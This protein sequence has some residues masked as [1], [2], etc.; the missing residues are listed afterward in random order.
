MLS[1]HRGHFM[2]SVSPSPP[3]AEG[4]GASS[5][6]G[7]ANGGGPK[8]FVLDSPRVAHQMISTMMPTKG[9]KAIRIHQPDLFVS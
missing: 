7:A 1:P 4:A 6:V 5:L 8:R 3:T 2:R 9:I